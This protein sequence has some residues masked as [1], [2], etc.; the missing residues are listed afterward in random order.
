VPD[1][2]FTAAELGNL[3]RRAK[4]PAFRPAV[5]RLRRDVARADA[6]HLRVPERP[7]G[8]YHDF[9]CPDHGVELRFDPAQPGEHR[10]P[11]D[12][13]RFSGERFDAAWRWFV[14]HH[15]AESTLRRAVLWR[16]EGDEAQRSAVRDVL[17]GYADRYA[18]YATCPR[19]GANPG[20]A[21]YTTLDESVWLIPLAW[22]HALV[23]DALAAAEATAIIDRLL[24]P[25]AEHLVRRR[26]DAIHNFTCWHNAAIATVGRLAGRG[27]LIAYAL[28]GRIGQR[29]QLRQGMLPDG[30]WLEGSMS[31]HFY[32]VWALLLSALAFRHDPRTSLLGE[33]ALPRSLLTPLA[34]AH[35]DGTLPA[36]ATACR[37][38]P[39]STNSRSHSS[40]IPPSPLPS[41]PRMHR[42]R[43]TACTRSC[44][45]RKR[46]PPPRLRPGAACASHPRDSQSCDPPS[47]STCCSSPDRTAGITAIRTNSP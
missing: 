26:Y 1:L 34:C 28:E 8:Y 43:A 3:R 6:M 18:F 13:A 37:R 23:A 10:C 31:Y 24:V 36:P 14:N 15:L 44:S 4:L 11:V 16:A 17:L 25:A 21:T 20:V 32:S 2:L 19:P 29:A 9:T 22:A 40:A 41:T 30:L 39:T 33:P 12:G 27:D 7:G 45:V 47:A 46:C 38:R 35:P 5:E 42:G